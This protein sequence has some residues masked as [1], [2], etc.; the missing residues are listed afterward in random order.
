MVSAWATAN[1]LVLAQVKVD[2]KSNEITALPELPR[3]LAISGCIVTI[4][5]MGWQ[6]E[7]AQQIVDQGGDYVLALKANQASLHEDVLDSFSQ[8]EKSSSEGVPH[9]YAETVDKGHGRILDCGR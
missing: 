8:A 5:A 4:H 7:I 9:D 2:E 3:C 1:R 6:R